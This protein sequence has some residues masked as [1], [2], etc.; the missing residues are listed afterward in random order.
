M[1]MIYVQQNN[2]KYGKTKRLFEHQYITD[3]RECIYLTLYCERPDKSI[4]D[5]DMEKRADQYVR[6]IESVDADTNE[7]IIKMFS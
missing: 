3:T 7:R 6:H 5:I 2:K 1:M 4:V